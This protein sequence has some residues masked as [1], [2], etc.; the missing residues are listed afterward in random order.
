MDRYREGLY[1]ESI[2]RIAPFGVSELLRAQEEFLKA[3]RPAATDEGLRSRIAV[4]LLHADAVGQLAV[5]RYRSVTDEVML[6]QDARQFMEGRGRGRRR[7]RNRRADNP[8]HRLLVEPLRT[9][10]AGWPDGVAALRDECAALWGVELAARPETVFRREAVLAAARGALAGFDLSTA[11]GVLEQEE[12][13]GDPAV[14]WQLAAVRAVRARLIREDR[15]W[16]QVREGFA[17]A[18]SRSRGGHAALRVSASRP[19]AALGDPDDRNL[20]LA[21]AAIGVGERRRARDHLREVNPEPASDL[22]VPRLLIEA[23]LRLSEGRMGSAVIGIEE[24][25]G[26]APD[27]QAV[28]AALVVALQ[29]VGRHEEAAA[30][31]SDLLGNGRRDRVWINFLLTWAEGRGRSFEWLREVVRTA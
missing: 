11:S 27:S 28:V 31:A 9:L 29:G 1:T 23:E 2:R 30:L 24:A 15:L 16:P 13:E 5:G 3:L 8:Y 12:P 26:L 7:R 21:L 17:E 10:P 22:R 25:V 14:I 18:A 4:A 6:Q 20:R 19:A